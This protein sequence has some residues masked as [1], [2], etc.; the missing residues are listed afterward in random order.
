[1]VIALDD[2]SELICGSLYTI[3]FLA[4]DEQT[5]ELMQAIRLVHFKAIQ[6]L[7]YSIAVK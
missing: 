3:V 6:R 2:C 4:L 1:M 5:I 7:F